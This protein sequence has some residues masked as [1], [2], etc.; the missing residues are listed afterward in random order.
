MG[1]R[2][3]SAC[4]WGLC[5]MEAPMTRGF[6]PR[7]FYWVLLPAVLLLI[8]AIQLYQFFRQSDAIWW[9]PRAMMIPLVESQD[10]VEIYVGD[11]HLLTLLETGQILV[12][13]GST[14]RVVTPSDVGLRL[15]N[16]DRVR[17]ARIPLLL[18]SATV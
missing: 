17:A 10:R 14:T 18:V 3:G 5:L 13:T 7:N 8:P 9:T 2:P 1:Q 12:T 11:T 6:T 4:Q 16:W 15:N